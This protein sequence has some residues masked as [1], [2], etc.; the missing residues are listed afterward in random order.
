MDRA[1]RDSLQMF[2][3]SADSGFVFLNVII[4]LSL[5]SLAMSTLDNGC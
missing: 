1:V 5:H 2:E 3:Q 4:A